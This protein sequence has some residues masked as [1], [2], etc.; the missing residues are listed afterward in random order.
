MAAKN[1]LT[2]GIAELLILSILYKKDSYGYEIV[3]MIKENSGGLI[4]LSYNTTYAATCKMIE[5]GLI[6]EKNV[7]VGK[8]RTRIYFH[9]EEKGRDYYNKLYDSYKNMSLGVDK[10]LESLKQKDEE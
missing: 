1:T 6:S 9:L 3:K 10:I 4:S 5:S 8:K 2:T 7:K